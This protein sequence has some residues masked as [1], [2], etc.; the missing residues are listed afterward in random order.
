LASIEV[1]SASLLPG[2]MEFCRGISKKT[3]IHISYCRYTITEALIRTNPSTMQC[4]VVR[5][6]PSNDPPE[7]LITLTFRTKL[8]Y[9][10]DDDDDVNWCVHPRRPIYT[11]GLRHLLSVSS[12]IYSLNVF[13]FRCMNLLQTSRVKVVLQ[14]QSGV[15]SGNQ[16][17]HRPEI[18][19][20]EIYSR[21]N[22][23]LTKERERLTIPE[24][25]FR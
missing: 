19:D 13:F 2:K 16:I 7:I 8:Q 24:S 1:R 10:C 15:I 6:A 14:H 12:L 11:T 22:I 21:P 5:E 25:L 17:S 23:S 3:S 18:G 4:E 20:R 9:S